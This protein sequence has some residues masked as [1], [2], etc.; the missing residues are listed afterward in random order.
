MSM[1]DNRLEAADLWPFC[2]DYRLYLKATEPTSLIST[3]ALMNIKLTGNLIGFPCQ[4]AWFLSSPAIITTTIINTI[5][6]TALPIIKEAV[7][8]AIAARIY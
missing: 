3:I 2:I 6:I 1:L 5:Y 7:E 8:V 4:C